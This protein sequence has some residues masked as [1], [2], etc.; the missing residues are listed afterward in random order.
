MIGR[1]LIGTAAVCAL[2]SSVAGCHRDRDRDRKS[3]D[4]KA[5]A[6]AVWMPA[7][8]P[9][10]PTPR[11]P[12]NNPA[13][14]VRLPD[15]DERLV[16]GISGYLHLSADGKVLLVRRTEAFRLYDVATGKLLGD[17]AQRG[18]RYLIDCLGITTAAISNDASRVAVLLSNGLDGYL[19]VID[20]K[21]GSPLNSTEMRFDRD[22]KG[23]T[24]AIAFSNKGDLVLVAGVRSRRIYAIEAESGALRWDVRTPW[25]PI[26]VAFAPDDATFAVS[27]AGTI[28]ASKPGTPTVVGT[29]C[30]SGNCFSGAN[31][32]GLGVAWFDRATGTMTKNVSIDGAGPM[33]PIAMHPDGKTVAVGVDQAAIVV[34]PAD[35]PPVSFAPVAGSV[36]AVQFSRD[37]AAL[38]TTSYSK[39]LAEVKR[40]DRASGKPTR[41][42]PLRVEP[43]PEHVK[44]PLPP[45]QF[46]LA[47]G[48]DLVA[49]GAHYWVDLARS[50]DGKPLYPPTRNGLEVRTGGFGDCQIG[51]SPR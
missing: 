15:A 37:G 4:S 35:T 49:W 42:R 36:S 50:A 14:F 28:D 10:G 29:H 6:G 26:S 5:D 1:R 7:E 25:M 39:T 17:F 43:F 31:L 9:D 38:T 51:K 33:V 44:P 30:L 40:W 41:A 16:D 32:R 2:A 48:G 3:V 34:D 24:A 8:M 21:T 12:V 18:G 23:G 11:W 22:L 13:R 27:H 19:Q 46:A 20:A 45:D 47:D